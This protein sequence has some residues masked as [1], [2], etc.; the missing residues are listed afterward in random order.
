MASEAKE[1]GLQA[2]KQGYLALRAGDLHKAQ[3]MAAKA[4]RLFPCAE[5]GLV[6][7]LLRPA[8]L[9]LL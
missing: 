4:H 7:V 3:R 8:A 1:N 9:Q 2:C 5:V 6:L